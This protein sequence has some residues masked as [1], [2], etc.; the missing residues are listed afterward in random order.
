MEPSGTTFPRRGKAAVRPE[1]TLR[2]RGRSG[3]LHASATLGRA[4]FGADLSAELV[5]TSTGASSPETW[6]FRSAWTPAPRPMALTG[7]AVAVREPG[8]A[9]DLGQLVDL[10]GTCCVGGRSPVAAATDRR[11]VSVAGWSPAHRHSR[12]ANQRQ[13]GARRRNPLTTNSGRMGPR[14]ASGVP[15]GRGSTRSARRPVRL[16]RDARV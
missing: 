8:R 7:V 15:A 3:R 6:T 2:R 9:E 1:G 4:V 5:A 13:R 16:N 12:L 10:S 11:R 14:T